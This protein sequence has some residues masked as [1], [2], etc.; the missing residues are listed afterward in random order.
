MASAMA[1]LGQIERPRSVQ[2][3]HWVLWRTETAILP[4]VV[5]R[6][7]FG[8]LMFA[9]TIRF[10]SNGWIESFYIQPA[11]HFTYYGFGWVKP[12]AGFWL[13]LIYALMALLS[14]CIALGAFYRVSMIGFFLLFTYSELLDKTYYLNHY[15]F[16]SLFS[17]LLIFLPLHR[18]TSFDSWRQ[19]HIRSTKVAVW[20]LWAVRFQLCIV[21]FFAGVAKLKVDW[22]VHAMPLRIWLAARSDFPLLGGFF[23]TSWFPYLMSWGGALYDLAIPFL[24]LNRRT[25]PWAYLAV[26][27]FHLITGLLFPIGIFPAIMIACTLVFFD[28]EDFERLWRW[29]GGS[30]DTWRR[31]T[32]EQPHNP[33]YAPT[34]VTKQATNLPVYSY[35]RLFISLIFAL[36]FLAQLILPL[37]HWLYPGNV[38]WTEEGY[39]FAWNV[40]LAEKTGHV[41]FTVVDP[42]SGRNWLVFPSDYLT[43]QQEKQMSFQPDMILEFAHYL[44]QQ[45]QMKGI[46]NAAIYAEAYVSLNG[47]PSQLLIDPTVNLANQSNSLLPKNWILPLKADPDLN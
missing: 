47:R 11:F 28:R 19:P 13:Y 35:S 2:R 24:L 8:L 14:L 31:F 32:A 34:I 37:R 21:Y 45:M 23:E 30:P 41:T 36:F 7:A 39:R 22:L 26:I 29:L 18:S 44:Q 3:L 5:L 6:V 40:M 16:V 46:D 10:M 17:F 1:G 27:G 42:A 33:A 20:A 12:V 4:L 25:R 15:Y 9:G 43:Y 38:L